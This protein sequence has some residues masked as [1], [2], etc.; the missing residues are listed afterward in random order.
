MIQNKHIKSFIVPDGSHYVAIC[1]DA[2]PNE[3]LTNIGY[4]K[5]DI[6]SHPKT[7][8][9]W[10]NS[11]LDGQ[12]LDSL[13]KLVSQ[14]VEDRH[15]KEYQ[16]NFFKVEIS[17]IHNLLSSQPILDWQTYQNQFSWRRFNPKSS[18]DIEIL[19][20]F[21]LSSFGVDFKKTESGLVESV[22]NPVKQEKIQQNLTKSYTDNQ[23]QI[24]LI[25]SKDS[26]AAGA[27]SLTDVCGD[28]QLNSVAGMSSQKTDLKVKKLPLILA[29][30]F[31]VVRCS[32]EFDTPQKLTFSNSKDKVSAI[33]SS[34]GI[35]KNSER[36]GLFVQK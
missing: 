26:Q 2:S 21:M 10:D 34:F 1:Q 6:I 30:V 11:D 9:V 5:T 23:N 32:E 14:L 36:K 27:F 28:I 33:Y 29:C 20:D 22:P 15:I 18:D 7:R 4:L 13:Q 17:Q 8:I 31:D 25:F 19:K 3:I 16:T 24:Y 35:S 12:I